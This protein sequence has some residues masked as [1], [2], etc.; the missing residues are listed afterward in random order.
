MTWT[1]DWLTTRGPSWQ[2]K[3]RRVSM[4]VRTA[5]ERAEPKP[6]LPDPWETRL[7]DLKGRVNDGHERVPAFVAFDHLELRRSERHSGAAR[8]LVRAMRHLGWERTRFQVTS[9]SFQRVRG[10]QRVAKG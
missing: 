5:Q 2:E 3:L 7:S 4:D 8:R 1:S 6:R 9:G 10:F